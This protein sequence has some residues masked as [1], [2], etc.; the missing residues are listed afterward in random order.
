MILFVKSE[1]MR[2][3]FLSPIYEKKKQKI[4]LTH[5]EQSTGEKAWTIW[6]GEETNREKPALSFSGVRHDL[7]SKRMGRQL[8][9]QLRRQPVY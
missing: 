4:N 3:L 9:S 1:I 7:S 2:K 5:A 8:S 6:M